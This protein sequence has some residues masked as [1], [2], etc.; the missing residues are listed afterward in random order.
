MF[1]TVILKYV[2][3]TPTR[4]LT[5]TPLTNLSVGLDMS[6]GHTVFLQAASYWCSEIC[7]DYKDQCTVPNHN[8]LTKLLTLKD[9]EL[10]ALRP[11]R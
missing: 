4:T 8:N 1:A 7:N 9:R 10:S 2:Q 5:C 6:S 11:V 3:R